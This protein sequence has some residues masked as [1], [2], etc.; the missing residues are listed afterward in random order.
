MVFQFLFLVLVAIIA[1]IVVLFITKRNSNSVNVPSSAVSFTS[2]QVLTLPAT[3]ITF[4][5]PK[6]GTYFV[7]FNAT[8]QSSVTQNINTSFGVN[9]TIQP[10]S[11]RSVAALANTPT[12]VSLQDT[13]Y[14]VA[15]TNSYLSVDISGSGANVTMLAASFTTLQVK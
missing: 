9:G 11:T 3:A 2:A 5:V 10:G 12:S 4:A 1:C 13:I 8:Y 14:L 15:G 6:T 7:V